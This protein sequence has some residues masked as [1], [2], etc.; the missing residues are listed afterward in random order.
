VGWQ[1]E[2]VD[3][4]VIETTADNGVT[5]LKLAIGRMSTPIRPPKFEDNTCASRHQLRD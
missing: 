1:D 4:R 3:Q 2:I 5:R